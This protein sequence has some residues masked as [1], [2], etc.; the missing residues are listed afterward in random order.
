VIP[1]GHAAGTAIVEVSTAIGTSSAAANPSDQ[2]SYLV[3][4]PRLLHLTP[5]TGPTSGGTIVTL[6]GRN[7]EGAS[8]VSFGSTRVVVRH[9]NAGGTRLT[10]RAPAELPGTV[11][12]R[13]TTPAGVSSTSNK[14]RFKYR[15]G[16]T[17]RIPTFRRGGHHAATR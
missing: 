4:R 1:A 9:V 7:L 14:T 2:Y 11:Q 17:K 12:I 3:G 5:S 10:V 8:A 15:A 13:V 16:L 6:T